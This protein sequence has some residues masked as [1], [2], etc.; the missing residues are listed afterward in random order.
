MLYVHYSV[1][2]CPDNYE[3]GPKGGCYRFRLEDVGTWWTYRRQ[4]CVFDVSYSD[5]LVINDQEEF[6]FVMNRTAEMSTNASWWIGE[7]SCYFV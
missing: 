7:I 4:A 2:S 5:L 1:S 6:D 3:E